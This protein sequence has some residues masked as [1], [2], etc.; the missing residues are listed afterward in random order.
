[1]WCVGAYGGGGGGGGGGD[2]GEQRTRRPSMRWWMAERN[3]TVTL[4][5][6]AASPS[7]NASET[8]LDEVPVGPPHRR[9]RH[10]S[11][12]PFDGHCPDDQVPCPRATES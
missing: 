11:V 8:R 1:M 10:V 4:R 12:P 7:G 6:W 9:R 3:T 5:R 2:G